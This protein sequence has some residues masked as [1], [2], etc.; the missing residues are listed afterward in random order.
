MPTGRLIKRTVTTE[1][2]YGDTAC[3]LPDIDD[4]DNDAIEDDDDLDDADEAAD[5]RSPRAPRGKSQNSANVTSPETA[6]TDADL[7]GEEDQ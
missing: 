4:D 5:T 7:T 6:G 3:A 1:E 2:L